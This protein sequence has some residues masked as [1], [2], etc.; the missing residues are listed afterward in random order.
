VMRWTARVKDDL[1]EIRG[2]HLSRRAPEIWS[3]RETTGVLLT[4]LG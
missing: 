4:I 1:A 3:S 2:L